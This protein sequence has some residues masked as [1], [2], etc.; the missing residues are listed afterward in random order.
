MIYQSLVSFHARARTH[1]HAH[2]RTRAPFICLLP[3]LDRL[4]CAEAALEEHR[5][6]E[7]GHSF[8]LGTKYS[9]PFKAEVTVGD[10]GRVPLEMGCY[11]LGM[12]R[13]LAAIVEVRQNLGVVV[14]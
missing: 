5:G 14:N 2:A 9:A 13:I 3:V 7:L 12:T 10:R 11:G 8:Y 6:I 1:T 4:R